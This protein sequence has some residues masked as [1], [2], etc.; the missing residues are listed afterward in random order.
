MTNS[1]DWWD[2]AEI[3]GKAIVPI[4]IGFT[5][6]TWNSQRT[7]QQ[8][9]ASMTTIAVGILSQEVAND[10]ND[11][12]R[13]WAISVLQSPANPPLLSDAA[14]VA[15]RDR[16]L[17][18]FLGTAKMQSLINGIENFDNSMREFQDLAVPLGEDLR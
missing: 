18:N 17:P 7:S 12:L 14:A 9:A 10:Q 8:T 15:L 2:K 4:V 3:I 13:I 5:V 1:K 6:L 11:P 16:V